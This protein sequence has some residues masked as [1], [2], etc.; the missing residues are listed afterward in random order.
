MNRLRNV[1]IIGSNRLVL[2][3]I[4]SAVRTY[5]AIFLKEIGVSPAMI[6][7][8]FSAGAIFTG[9][10]RILGGYIADA[11]GRKRIVVSLTYA[12]ALVTL[13]PYFRPTYLGILV[14]FIASSLTGFYQPA[15]FALLQDSIPE[16]GRGRTYG[17]FN[18]FTMRGRL[19]GPLLAA[20]VVKRYGIYQ[21]VRL[22]F[23]RNAIILLA[24]AISRHFLVETL[25]VKNKQSFAESY[26]HALRFVIDRVPSLLG[27]SLLSAFT[28]GIL[29]PVAPLYVVYYKGVPKDQRG[30]IARLA[31]LSGLSSLLRGK[32]VDKSRTRRF[33]LG[34]AIIIAGITLIILAPAR[35]GLLTFARITIG[36]FI[37]GVGASAVNISYNVIIID[38]VP[39]ELR[40]RFNAISGFLNGIFNGLGNSLGGYEYSIDPNLPLVTVILAYSL[41]YPLIKRIRF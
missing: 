25:S 34:V 2:G 16:K 23:L 13:I 15:L 28:L 8:A 3:F 17:Y 19:F 37:A 40:G 20:F 9:I 35:S 36:R 32:L 12:L 26:S 6:G 38:L 1:Y 7:L 27:I 5:L 14:R 22:L 21:G 39:L 18:A 30:I 29:G 4:N 31:G 24:V 11:H 33:K 10:A 41:M